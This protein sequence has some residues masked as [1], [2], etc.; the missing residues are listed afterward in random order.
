M[1]DG[2]EAGMSLSQMLTYTYLGA[3]FSDIL[4]VRSQASSW[5]YEELIMGLYQ[6]PLEK[7]ERLSEPM[8]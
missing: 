2:V 7:R 1:V 6:R 8:A 4:I 5:L 3:V